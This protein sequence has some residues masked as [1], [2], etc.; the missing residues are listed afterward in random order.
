[1]LPT[2]AYDTN[3][4]DLAID[5][6]KVTLDMNTRRAF[7][8][9]NIQKGDVIL[10]IP[11]EAILDINV[12]LKCETI[13]KWDEGTFN[14]DKTLVLALWVYENIKGNYIK[15]LKESTPDRLNEA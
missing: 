1:V 10:T 3:H 5:T 7:A 14:D 11:K 2:K 8:V 13:A 12:A 4:Y 15:T 6:S 9:D